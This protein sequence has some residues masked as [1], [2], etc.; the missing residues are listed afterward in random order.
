ML[1][2]STGSRNR[3]SRMESWNL[4]LYSIFSPLLRQT[5]NLASQELTVPICRWRLHL[6]HAWSFVLCDLW[7]FYFIISLWNFGNNN[8]AVHLERTLE[9]PQDVPGNKLRPPALTIR[10]KP[11]LVSPALHAA[12]IAAVTSSWI[13]AC[14]RYK[15]KQHNGYRSSSCLR[16]KQQSCLSNNQQNVS[17][18]HTALWAIYHKHPSERHKPY[19]RPLCPLP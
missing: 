15:A 12:T 6:G 13:D 10:S 14:P 8:P 3:I 19:P 11:S 17:D 4:A 7:I 1:K 2:G 5:P 18:N 16:R 9:L